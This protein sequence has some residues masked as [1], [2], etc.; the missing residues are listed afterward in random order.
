[1]SNKI[2]N[3]AAYPYSAVVHIEVVTTTGIYWHGS[4][5][6]VGRNDVLT[7][8]HVVYDPHYDIANM[9][10][11][12][13]YSGGV[14]PYGYTLAH[15]WQFDYVDRDGNG[16]V[17]SDE[18]A[19]DVALVTLDTPLGDQTGWFNMNSSF[20]SG[21]LYKDGYPEVYGGDVMIED[22]GY[23]YSSWTSDTID[24]SIMEINAGDSGGPLW[25]YVSGKPTVYGVVSTGILAAPVDAWVISAAQQ[26]DS[27]IA[28]VGKAAVY[29]FLNVKNGAHFFTDSGQERDQL[30]LTNSTYHLEGW[31]FSVSDGSD[32]KDAPVY[33]FYN[34]KTN[35]HFWTIAQAE[36]D[37]LKGQI[38]KG[39]S[40]MHYDGEVFSAYTTAATGT[41]PLYRF[42]DD[43]SGSHFYT[44]NTHER[45]QIINTLHHYHYE[46]IAFYVFG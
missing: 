39:A 37:Y 16:L 22:Y 24:I 21:F 42:Y 12:P 20:S 40:K 17:S 36:A 41:T 23:A 10:I 38:S 13:A 46:G 18:S 25:S 3:T 27:L 1:M 28:P 34:P 2:T 31:T 26:N 5:V 9:I 14:E 43:A 7:A 11:T 6:M 35:A 33:R 4:G 8:A 30:I 29:R 44:S 45:D 15:S 19:I 32:A